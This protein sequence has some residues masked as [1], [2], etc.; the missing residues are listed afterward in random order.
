MSIIR[1]LYAV[2]D[3]VLTSGIHCIANIIIIIVTKTYCFVA[4]YMTNKLDNQ[5]PYSVKFLTFFHNFV[6]LKL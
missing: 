3:N 1:T 4:Q 6:F 2:P 5:G